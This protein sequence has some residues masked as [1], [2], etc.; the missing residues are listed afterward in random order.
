MTDS[1]VINLFINSNAILKHD[2]LWFIQGKNT[3]YKPL[4]LGEYTIQEKYCDKRF[5]SFL[6][7]CMVNT[8]YLLRFVEIYVVFPQSL[9]SKRFLVIMGCV[10]Q[11]SEHF[12]P[13]VC[14]CGVFK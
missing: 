9:T 1:F 2:A 4:L 8:I 14:T 6:Y 10:N 13:S 12:M 3:I 5:L 11:F 7:V